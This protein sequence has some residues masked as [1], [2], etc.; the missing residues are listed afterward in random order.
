MKLF[1]GLNTWAI[2]LA[3]AISFIFGGIW[4]GVLSKQWLAAAGL[5]P[6]KLENPRGASPKPLVIAFVAQL[7]M[8]WL[9]AGLLLHLER[10]GM[11]MSLRNGAV[12]ALFVWLGFVV[13]PLVVNYQFQ[14]RPAALGA[15]DCGHWLGVLLIQGAILGAVG[16]A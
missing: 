12:S 4:Y 13:P 2:P 11:T 9:L 6:D 15:I 14:M 10:S 5:G 8:A 3:A 1:A 7:V 16:L